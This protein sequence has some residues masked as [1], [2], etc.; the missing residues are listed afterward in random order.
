M[1]LIKSIAGAISTE[2]ADQWKEF[3]YCEAM[4]DD[5]LMSKGEKRVNGKKSSNTKGSDNIISQG[6]V[7]AVNDGQCMIIVEQGLIVDFTAEPG[8]YTF[9]KSTEPSMFAGSFGDGLK[10]TF[11]QIGKRFTFGGDTGKDQRVYFVNT[12]QI[13]GNKFGTASP[14]PFRVVDTNIGL[15]VD[16]AIR[17]NGEYVF[18]ICNPLLFYSNV[19][20]NV[21]SVYEKETIISQMRSELL[22]A[23]QPAFAKISMMGI[24]YSL[25]PGH[26]AELAQFLQTELS[27]K[28][29]EIRGMEI[30]T[31]G[32]N[33]VNASE[34]DEK[35]IKELQRTAVFRNTGMAAANINAAQADAMK[36]AASNESAGPMM[37]FAGM[38]MAMNAGGMNSNQ[39]YQMAQGQGQTNPAQNMNPGG[40][41]P[42]TPDQMQGQPLDNPMAFGAMAGA[43]NAGGAQPQGE[44]TWFCPQCGFKNDA[45]SAFCPQCGTKNPLK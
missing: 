3:I 40:T 42:M 36:M 6:S 16:I 35:M 30:V 24:R 20:A 39:L 7:I 26:T 14:V 25:I 8:A 9:D 18:R 32:I 45:S 10:K 21:E 34:E 12:K 27:P 43:Q 37:A 28:W 2:L 23:L 33:A 4:S 22:T 44:G 1:G 15:D 13:Q 31:V 38:N 29:T 19:A 11:A 17:C 5:I 41:A